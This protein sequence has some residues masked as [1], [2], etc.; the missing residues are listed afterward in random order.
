MKYILKYVILYTFVAALR[1]SVRSSVYRKQTAGHEHVYGAEEYDSEKDVYFR[2]CT[3]CDH[4]QVY[5][6]M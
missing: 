6:K 4:Q 1:M 3:T 2:P 5:E